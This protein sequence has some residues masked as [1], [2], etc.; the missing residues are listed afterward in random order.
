MKEEKLLN[1]Q[2]GMALLLINI[3]LM[4]ASI[5]GIIFAGRSM[6]SNGADAFS[7]TLLSVSI[8]YIGIIGPILFGGLKVLQPNEAYVLTLFGKYYCTL[9]GE[10]FFFVN[11]FVVAVNPIKTVKPVESST[12]AQKNVGVA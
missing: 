5:L 6:D 10:G 1:A 8:V 11:P 12:S 3:L 4:L 7:V 2:N 9:K